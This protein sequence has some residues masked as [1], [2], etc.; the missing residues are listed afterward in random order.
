M[1]FATLDLVDAC[2]ALP[3]FRT[4]QIVQLVQLVQFVPSTP[5]PSILGRWLKGHR[6]S[7]SILWNQLFKEQAGGLKGWAMANLKKAET[8]CL[9]G[10]GRKRTTLRVIELSANGSL[11]GSHLDSLTVEEY[12]V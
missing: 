12:E 6:K 3:D 11:E 7:P 5:S 2:K 1:R 10:E 9:E 4:F 8:R